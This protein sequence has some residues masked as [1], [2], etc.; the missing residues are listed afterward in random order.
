MLDTVVPMKANEDTGIGTGGL[1][2]SWH[3]RG[4]LTLWRPVQDSVY[5]GRQLPRD[6]LTEVR[7]MVLRNFWL[8]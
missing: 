1:G 8:S 4:C 6:L 3:L 2:S 7:A 5:M